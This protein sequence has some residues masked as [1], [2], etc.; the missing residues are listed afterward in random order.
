MF[1]L[2]EHVAGRWKPVDNHIYRTHLRALTAARTRTAQHGRSHR[3]LDLNDKTIADWVAVDSVS[4]SH[5]RYL[6]CGTLGDLDRGAR[7]PTNRDT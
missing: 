6:R 5:Y 7:R 1:R 3:V 2:E 4:R